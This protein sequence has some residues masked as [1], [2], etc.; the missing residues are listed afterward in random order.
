MRPGG[1]FEPCDGVVDI[2]FGA[3]GDRGFGWLN[4]VRRPTDD[5]AVGIDDGEFPMNRWFAVVGIFGIE[6]ANG[7]TAPVLKSGTVLEWRF[8]AWTFARQPC[9][10][11]TMTIEKRDVVAGLF[12]GGRFWGERADSNTV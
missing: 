12:L 8:R 6:P 2:G 10:E 5:A 9:D 1:V 3:K 7:L 4:V 11:A